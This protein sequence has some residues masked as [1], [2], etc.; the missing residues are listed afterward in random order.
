M[1]FIKRF[2]FVSL[3]MIFCL[4]ALAQDTLPKFSA[5]NLGNNRIVIGWVN[6]FPNIKQISIQRSFDSLRNYKTIL[7]VA[8]PK[9]VQNGFADTK[10]PNNHM[11]YRIFYA[12]EGGAF[13]FT[14]AKRPFYDSTTTVTEVKPPTIIQKR[15]EGFVPSFYVYTNREG[16]VHI[17]LPDA[18]RKKYSIK[19]YEEDGS[20]LFD[21]KTV[22]ETSLT[23]DKANFYHAGWFTFE[24]FDDEKLVEKHKF[25]LAKDF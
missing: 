14:E 15:P 2:G 6:Q 7:S 21:L 13:Y 5:R 11:F 8:D 9:A 10:A 20:F 23:L 4:F 19:F 25:Y 1:I 3:G 24:L 17:S 16:Y 12:M 22:K 18:A